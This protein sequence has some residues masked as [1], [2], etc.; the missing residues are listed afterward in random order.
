MMRGYRTS[1]PRLAHDAPGR[2]RAR[3]VLSAVGA[4]WVLSLGFDLLLHA[5]LLA[6]LYIKPS[7]FLLQPEE[8]FRRIPLGY[9]AFL[10]LVLSLYWLFRRLG[11]HGVASGLR[12]GCVVGWAVWGA[13]VVGLYSIS[14][15][16]PPLLVGWW[17][18][19]GVELGLA[20]AVLGAA[21]GGVSLKRIWVVV[22][23][24]CI[25]CLAA[26]VVLQSFGLAPA[27]KKIN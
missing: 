17:I 12:H 6:K 14:T 4:A 8:A 3:R 24:A 23:L 5:G 15:A 2:L 21:A 25:G 13:V 1:A 10:G 18:G 9:L 19:Q 16:A 27:M 11:I 26:T 20:G 7:P 22:V